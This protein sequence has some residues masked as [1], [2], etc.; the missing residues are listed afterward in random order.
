MSEK[1]KT[2]VS[3]ATQ[4]KNYRVHMTYFTRFIKKGAEVEEREIEDDIEIA[5]LSRVSPAHTQ[6]AATL[7]DAMGEMSIENVLPSAKRFAEMMIVDDK[8]RNAIINDSMACIDLFY[9][10]AVQKDI[11]RFLEP[12]GVVKR[13]K[14][15]GDVPTSPSMTE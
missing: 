10:D 1:T 13:L 4:I 12:W 14:A 7:L 9:S 15:A 6:F 2:A 5:M 3:T 8:I 11:E